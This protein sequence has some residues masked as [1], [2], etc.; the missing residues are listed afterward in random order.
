M[1]N[2]R[3]NLTFGASPITFEKARL[4]KRK[5]TKAEKILWNVLRGGQLHGYKFRRQ[6]PLLKYIADFYCHELKLIIE[7]DGEIHETEVAREYDEA[8]TAQ[9]N[10]IGLTVLRF[11]NED[12]F[13]DTDKVLDRLRKEIPLI[14]S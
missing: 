4:L 10:Q 8:R 2:Y 9:L 12:V 6:H 1:K 5:M 14:P 13:S 3:K 11:K 7:L